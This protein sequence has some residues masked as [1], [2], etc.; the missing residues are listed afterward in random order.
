MIIYFELA[1]M[2]TTYT[3]HKT[4]QITYPYKPYDP[5]PYSP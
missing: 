5:Y 2:A 3:I 1:I 4:L